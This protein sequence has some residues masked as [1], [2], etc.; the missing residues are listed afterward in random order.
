MAQEVTEFPSKGFIGDVGPGGGTVSCD[1]TRDTADR[2]AQ[3]PSQAELLPANDN[4]TQCFTKPCT[5]GCLP[6]EA[7]PSLS[8]HAA[9]SV[10]V[11]VL[12]GLLPDRPFG[13]GPECSLVG[14][15]LA[16]MH[17]VL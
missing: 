5:P 12:C 14:Q 10:L 13:Q 8:L 7:L 1:S 2:D 17:N 15:C 4:S 3:W 16:G 6:L 9:G 11:T